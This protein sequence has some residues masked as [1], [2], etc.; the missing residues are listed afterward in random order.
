MHSVMHCKAT[1]NQYCLYEPYEVFTLYFF[2]P[3]K[4][5]GNYALC[6]KIL[7]SIH[8]GNIFTCFF[9]NEWK[10]NPNLWSHVSRDVFIYSCLKLQSWDSVMDCL[11]FFFFGWG[12]NK[13][14][15]LNTFL[16]IFF[17][18]NISWPV[19][20]LTSHP[21]HSL[22]FFVTHLSFFQCLLFWIYE[23]KVICQY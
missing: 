21:F 3:I 13:W 22:F 11:F 12:D 6:L 23:S 19:I 5:W 15:T 9:S 16:S 7:F 17:F 2:R 4:T 8:E 14:G 18:F 20:K 1:S 10:S